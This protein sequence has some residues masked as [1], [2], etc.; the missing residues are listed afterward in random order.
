MIKDFKLDNGLQLN[1][2]KQEVNKLVKAVNIYILKAPGDVLELTFDG[3]VNF[4]LQYANQ[5]Y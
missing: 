3:F 4:M 1:Y 5:L 2:L